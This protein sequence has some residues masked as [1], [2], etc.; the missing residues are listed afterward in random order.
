MKPQGLSEVSLTNSVSAPVVIS[1]DHTVKLVMCYLV[2]LSATHL[3]CC[4][5]CALILDVLS[6]F[7][8][9][10]NGNV[11]LSLFEELT[12]PVILQILNLIIWSLGVN[13]VLTSLV[14]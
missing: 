10:K 12:F 2:Q 14:R 8:P 9:E 7:L 4:Y 3:S 6:L 11:D 13:P 1:T 5:A